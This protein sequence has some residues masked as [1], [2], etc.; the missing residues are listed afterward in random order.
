MHTRSRTLF[1]VALLLGLILGPL[2]V[3]AQPV[4]DA[5]W[6]RIETPS[7]SG[8]SEEGLQEARAYSDS[9]ESAAVVVVH[10]GRIVDEW[11]EVERTFKCHSIRKSFLSALYGIA[12]Q[13]RTIDPS[14]TVGD[15]GVDDEP[16]LTEKEKAATVRM[17]LKARSG[18]Y[19]DALYETPAMEAARPERGSHAPGPSGTTTIGTSTPSGPSTSK[20]PGERS[21]RPSRT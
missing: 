6:T 1:F 12:V 7:A 21:T 5:S 10:D 15:L 16:P 2:D 3:P 18:V 8:W 17:L 20:R 13:R 11:G 14:T 19:H 4:P 9:M